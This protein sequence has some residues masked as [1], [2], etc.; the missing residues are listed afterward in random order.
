[1]FYFIYYQEQTQKLKSAGETT[2]MVIE[3][4]HFFL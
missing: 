4:M 3:F 1:M 2:E